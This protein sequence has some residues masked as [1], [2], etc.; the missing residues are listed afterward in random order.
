[1]TVKTNKGGQNSAQK[2]GTVIKTVKCGFVSGKIKTLKSGLYILR[3]KFLELF[4][5][6]I[7]KPLGNLCKITTTFLIG[8]HGNQFRDFLVRIFSASD[9]S[10]FFQFGAGLLPAGPLCQ[11]TDRYYYKEIFCTA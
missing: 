1:M 11:G 2:P 5:A 8:E 6:D 7:L 10:G 4:L 3:S 9:T